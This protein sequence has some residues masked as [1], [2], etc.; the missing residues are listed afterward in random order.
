MLRAF[1]SKWP[2]RSVHGVPGH[3]QSVERAAAVLRLLG[4]GRLALVDLSNSLGLAK[5]TVHGILRTLQHVGFV[6]QDSDTG[7][8]Q[9]GAGLLELGHRQL[10]VNELRS[11]ALNW[12]DALAAR[13]GEAVRIGSHSAGEVVVVHHVFRPDDSV[14]TVEVGALLPLHASA[15]GKAITA[16]DTAAAAAVR[17]KGLTPYTRSTI[18]SGPELARALAAV[19][20][21]DWAAEVEE[22]TLGEAGVAAPV[23]DATG[24]VVASL[25]VSGPVERLCDGRRPRPALVTQ[26]RDAARAVSRELGAR[27]P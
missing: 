3:V 19:R 6:E 10:D 23:R 12:A 11:R 25:G 15:L 13:S 14:Q 1:R 9:L 27:A 4:H 24:L 16:F 2:T 18:A 7:H 8:Y 20:A 17:R 26:V 22:M 5:G 21:A